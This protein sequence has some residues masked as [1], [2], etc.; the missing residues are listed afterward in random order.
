MT[1]SDPGGERPLH[2]VPRRTFVQSSVVLAGGL[3]AG[4]TVI[5]HPAAWAESPHV[6]M[7]NDQ[8]VATPGATPMA[9]AVADYIPVVLNDAEY[10]AL[11]AMIE[12]LIPTDDLGAGARD[13][14][15]GVFID[16][17]LG[18]ANA[19]S[20]SLYQQGLAALDAAA[21]GGNFAALTDTQQDD[22]LTSV[23][24]GKV[25]DVPEAFFQTVLGHTRQGM[26]GDPIYGGNRDFAGWDLL[27]YPGIK[28]TWTA[29]EQAIDTDVTLEH[30][31]VGDLGGTPF[32]KG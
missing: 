17:S 14:G 27:G 22:L 9:T 30:R 12:R 18:N 6:R 5:S 28:L 32:V 2:L 20:L 8:G 31:S 11:N 3:A 16:S 29:E 4:G 24:A 13:A 1:R 7:L 26:F 21:D 10:A 23:A 19:D 25:T 15:A